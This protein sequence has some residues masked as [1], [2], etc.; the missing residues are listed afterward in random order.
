M[1]NLLV[2]ILLAV[3]SV[4]SVV[5]EVLFINERARRFEAE[6]QLKL[7]DLLWQDACKKLNVTIDELEEKIVDYKERDEGRQNDGKNV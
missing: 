4:M 7:N 5:F 6:M 3:I 1:V 2:S